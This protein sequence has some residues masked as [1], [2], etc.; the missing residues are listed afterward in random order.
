MKNSWIAAIAPFI[1]SVSLPLLGSSFVISTIFQNKAVIDS[2]SLM[3]WGLFF[4]AT[5]ILMGFMLTPT[6]F[7]AMISGYLLGFNAILPVVFMY[8][9][10]ASIGYFLGK[11]LD[12]GKVEKTLNYFNKGHLIQNIQETD[13]WF[14][15]TCRLSPV[16][17]FAFT[18]IVLA[19]INTPFKRFIT[20]GTLGMLPRTLLAIWAGKQATDIY[21]LENNTFT[22]NWETSILL[23]LLLISFAMLSFLMKKVI[24]KRG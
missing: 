15:F 9:I 21:A 8:T 13:H 6:T 24:T 17:P 18:N 16:L 12:Q 10:A 4:L 23:A 1:L 22:W 5:S 7:I 19:S 2:F 14:V 3:E 11:L 20:W